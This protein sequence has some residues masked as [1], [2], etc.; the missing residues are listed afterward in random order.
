MAKIGSLV[1]REVKEKIGLIHDSEEDMNE[2]VSEVVKIGWSPNIRKDIVGRIVSVLPLYGDNADIM[3]E[4]RP[5]VRINYAEKDSRLMKKGDPYIF[6]TVHVRESGG[7][8]EKGLM[9]V[10]QQEYDEKIV[11]IISGIGKESI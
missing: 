9:E 8:R 7:K 11:E 1:M 6:Y 5:E 4:K 3:R 10:L 2:R